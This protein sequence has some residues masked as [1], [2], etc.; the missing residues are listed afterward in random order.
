VR[1]HCQAQYYIDGE[2]YFSAVKKELLNAKKYVYITDWMITPYFQ[3]ER[4]SELSDRNSRLDYILETIALQGVKV[5]II[6]Y[7]EP[8]IALNNDS[9]F[10]ENY[11][12]EMSKNIKVLR[13]PNFI[14]IPFLWSHH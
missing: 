6:L 14:L 10:V 13:H 11:F 2:N 7:M 12:H 8:K 3:L 4:P 5:Y 1:N 9:E